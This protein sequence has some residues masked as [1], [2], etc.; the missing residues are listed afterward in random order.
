[1]LIFANMRYFLVLQRQ[2][3]SSLSKTDEILKGPCWNKTTAK[4]TTGTPELFEM[5]RAPKRDVDGGLAVQRKVI[6]IPQLAPP[7]GC[8]AALE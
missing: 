1:M 5:F 3:S 6:S 4:E 7:A 2:G 8:A